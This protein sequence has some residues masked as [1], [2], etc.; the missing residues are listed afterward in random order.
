MPVG[1]P[2]PMGGQLV[3]LVDA[4]G[5]ERG[6]AD[7]AAAHRP[8][9]MLHAAVSVVVVDEAGRVLIQRRA[10]GKALFGSWWSNS[11]CTHPAVGERLADAGERRARQE[12][13]M[14]VREVVEAGVFTYRARDPGSGLVEFERDT[15]LLARSSDEPA[16]DAGEVAAWEW[17]SIGAL[18]RGRRLTPWAER[19]HALGLACLFGTGAPV[20]G[21]GRAA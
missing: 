20:A 18:D 2:D 13:G 1:G 15:V 19:V 10:P 8:P 5:R 4:D 12:L 3:V 11:C 16:V 17:V 21:A 9:G 7:R 14:D 6:T